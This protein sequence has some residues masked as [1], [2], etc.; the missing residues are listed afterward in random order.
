MK[1][2]A[3]SMGSSKKKEADAKSGC[4]FLFYLPLAG[5][6]SHFRL[7]SGGIAQIVFCLHLKILVKFIDQ[8]DAGGDIHL[9]DR[10]F[11]Q[12]F[13]IFDQRPQRIAMGGDKIPW[14]ISSRAKFRVCIARFR[15]EV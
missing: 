5:D 1:T 12:A 10:L 11:G 2:P 3:A 15:Y 13:E 7:G 14:S 4:F 6:L 9:D 8:R